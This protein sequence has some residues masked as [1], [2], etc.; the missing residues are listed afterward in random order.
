MTVSIVIGPIDDRFFKE[1]NGLESKQTDRFKERNGLEPKQTD[2]FK[3]RNG[4]GRKLKTVHTYLGLVKYLGKEGR[5]VYKFHPSPD[6]TRG[7]KAF[8]ILVPVVQKTLP[9][10]EY[11]MLSDDNIF[12]ANFP[13]QRKLL[14]ASFVVDS[15][16]P[17]TGRFHLICFFYDNSTLSFTLTLHRRK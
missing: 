6:P 9:N 17:P 15:R 10:I 5:W 12:S 16:M 14:L 4:Y 1:R 2:G 3:E 13:L 11:L 7:L 8:I